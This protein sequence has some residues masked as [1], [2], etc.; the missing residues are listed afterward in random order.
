M[1][2]KLVTLTA[3]LTA[4]DLTVSCTGETPL[5][6]EMS[7]AAVSNFGMIEAI[8]IPIAVIIIGIRLNSLRH[9]FIPLPNL[10]CTILLS[11]GMMTPISKAIRIDPLSP[12]IMISL[13]DAVCFDYCLFFLVRFREE[14]LDCRKSLESSVHASLLASGHVILLSGFTLLCTFLILLVFPSGFLASIGWSCG[15]VMI[16]ALLCNISIT[17]A[18]ILAFPSL[19]HFDGFKVTW[20]TECCKRDR[21]E[22]VVLD[23]SSTIAV[24]QTDYTAIPKPENGQVVRE[25]SIWIKLGLFVTDH[26]GWVLLISAMLAAPFL[27]FILGFRPT[28]DENLIFLLDGTSCNAFKQMSA[29]FPVGSLDPYSVIAVSNQTNSILSPT[30]FAFESDLISKLL[31]TQSAFLTA[32]S[33]NALSFFD[34]SPVSFVDAVTYLSNSS[35]PLY[36]STRAFA[37]RALVAGSGLLNPDGSA[38]LIQLFSTQPP[39]SDVMKTFVVNTR[40]LLT[41]ASASC[42]PSLPISL[43]LYGAYSP[44]LDLQNKLYSYTA[45]DI[46]LSLGLVLTFIGFSFGSVVL[47]LRLLVTVVVSLIVTY[48][49]MVLIFQPGSF[50]N[51][52]IP[53]APSLKYSTGIYWLVRFDSRSSLMCCW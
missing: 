7:A 45:L 12:S 41:D 36:N 42:P 43:Y 21:Q 11:F 47:A 16:A 26:A 4:S 6:D 53:I 52:L 3:S 49:F 39:N 1:S 19:A 15:C 51:A 46:C 50:Q 18:L 31:T 44:Q 35:S 33:V 5:F 20:L 48:G 40:A 38:A 25:P 32:A 14:I 37:Y 23:E 13:A 17:P 27:Y 34:S 24:P 8:V 2:Q 9:L 30:Y 10:L 22:S 29:S 28:S